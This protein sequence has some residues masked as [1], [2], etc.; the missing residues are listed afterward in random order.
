MNMKEI[1][2]KT[3]ASLLGLFK[4]KCIGGR[5]GGFEGKSF[6]IVGMSGVGCFK[7]RGGFKL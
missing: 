3:F 6:I 7:S 2:H 1:L 4:K 5:G